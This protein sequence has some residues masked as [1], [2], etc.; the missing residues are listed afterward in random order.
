MTVPDLIPITRCPICGSA[1]PRLI[2][3]AVPTIHPDSDLR[4]DLSQCSQCRHWWNTPVPSQA[5]LIALYQADSPFVV[6]AGWDRIS[7]Q[8]KPI[9]FFDAK[10]IDYPY[11]AEF[12]SYLEIGCGG[13]QMLAHMKRRLP[14]CWGIEPGNWCRDP[15][16][17]RRFSDLPTEVAF[18]VLVLQDVIEHL[19]EPVEALD[20]YSRRANPG[21]LLFVSFPNRDA[22]VARCRR[23]RW[24]MV[25]PFGHLNYFSAASMTL[26]L[27]NCGWEPIT[28]YH[29]PHRFPLSRW[30]T[31][32]LPR[33]LKRWYDN[34]Q[35]FVVGK[36]R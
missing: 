6:S 2:S 27:K 18:D 17:V 24:G 12:R 36:K 4:I 1:S 15:N 31:Y 13:G 29:G 26:L 16:A 25:R 21:A 10:I 20:R 33:T 9:L 32:N 23:H 5:D 34:D 19:R 30:Q 14:V 22:P 3:N 35:W 11:P 7:Q 28:I 8:E